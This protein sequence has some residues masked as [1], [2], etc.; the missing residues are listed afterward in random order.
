MRCVVVT[1]GR[2][3]DDRIL[4]YEV[5]NRLKI[6]M[7]YVGD[8]N[9]ADA[10]ARYWA[11]DRGI[12]Y[13]EYKADWKTHGKAAGPI[14]NKEMLADAGPYSIVVAFPG[15]AGTEDCVAQALTWNRIVLRVEK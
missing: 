3:Y 4:V 6:D 13:A 9:G 5:L 8:A 1:G 10:L 2:K 15:N 14:R 11:Q 12:V 7:L